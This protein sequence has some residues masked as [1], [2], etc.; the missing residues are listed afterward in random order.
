MTSEHAGPIVWL[1]F[2]GNDLLDL[3]IDI[4]LYDFMARL[5]AFIV[6]AFAL[7]A[8]AQPVRALTPLPHTQSLRDQIDETFFAGDQISKTKIQAYRTRLS[9]RRDEAASVFA[10]ELWTQGRGR[11]SAGRRAARRKVVET[12]DLILGSESEEAWLDELARSTDP[13][14]RR[15]LAGRILELDYA[16]LVEG[17]APFSKR[18]PEHIASIGF[19]E[20]NVPASTRARDVEPS[21]ANASG[22]LSNSARSAGV[23]SRGAARSAGSAA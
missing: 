17:M 20:W 7:L 11:R 8:A 10:S 16:L 15:I 5:G 6:I 19:L 13:V 1:Y 3:E 12:Y 2:E 23:G 9:Q 14:A 18:L 22:S 4:S 21:A